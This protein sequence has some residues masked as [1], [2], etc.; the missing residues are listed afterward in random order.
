MFLRL[1]LLRLFCLLEEMCDIAHK[2]EAL[3]FV[4]EVH[5][6]GL[7]GREGV[8]HKIDIISG[9]LGTA[10][11]NVGG[12]IAASR[13]LVDVVRS[14]GAGFIFTTSLPP[15]VLSGAITSIQVLRSAEGRRLRAKHMANV[16]Y[17]RQKLISAGLSVGHTPSHIIPIHIGDPALCSALSDGLIQQFGHYVQAINFPTV[18]R[19][20]EMLRVA[21][22]PHHTLDMMDKFVADLTTIWNELGLLIKTN[23]VCRGSC[24]LFNRM[25]AR[26]CDRPYCPQVRN[27][28]I[29]LFQTL[30]FPG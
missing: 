10:F 8:E 5:A 29:K 1:W 16:D 9:T 14:Y 28:N 22:T 11:G 12:Y 18:P 23:P 15:T 25:S 17:L 30:D 7:Y 24:T 26:E 2:Y 21:P 6:V 20:D 3:T 19:G 27:G 13:G 4:D